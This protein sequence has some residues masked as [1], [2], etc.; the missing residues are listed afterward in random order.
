MRI[1]KS[2]RSKFIVLVV[3][4]CL[5]LSLT[6]SWFLTR[7]YGREMESIRQKQVDEIMKTV[8]DSINVY[9]KR[10]NLLFYVLQNNS[11][12]KKILRKEEYQNNQELFQD[13]ET[14]KEILKN[15]MIGEEYI[16]NI[17]LVSEK[18]FYFSGGGSEVES[19][20]NGLKQY[21]KACEDKEIGIIVEAEEDHYGYAKLKF[22]KKIQVT[23]QAPEFWCVM[24]VSCKALY[25]SYIGENTYKGTLIVYDPANKVINYKSNHKEIKMTDEELAEFFENFDKTSGNIQEINEQ[26][27][28]ISCHKSDI[29]DW[30]NYILIPYSDILGDGKVRNMITFCLA[31]F[32]VLAAFGITAR[33]SKYFLKNIKLLT[34][35]VENVTTE[36]L[37]I[38]C[39]IH[40]GDEVEQLYNSFVEMTKR[41]NEEM[42]ENKKSERE[43]IYLEQYALQ[44]QIKPHFLYNTLYTIKMLATMTGAEAIENITEALST[45]M[46]VNMSA[47]QFYTFTEAMD[48]LEKYICI[49]EYQYVG[50]I[51]FTYEIEKGLEQKY[52]LKM[53]LQPLVENSIK[54]GHIL[55]KENGKIEV[56]IFSEDAKI[57]AEVYDNGVGMDAAVRECIRR[58]E[59]KRIGLKNIA[60]R[61]QLYYGDSYGME[62]Q[63]VPGEYTRV[64]LTLP[65]EESEEKICLR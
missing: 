34:D 62:I 24:T 31:L 12:V 46:Q 15:A 38:D 64:I 36:H 35:S 16:R 41:L 19:S 52:I 2:L 49:R 25:K 10:M 22:I 56:R 57:K 1:R 11:S 54:H 47:E 17:A 61:I 51:N 23:E 50:E 29:V 7:M 28:F 48:Y 59:T 44:A 42:E 4:E 18:G 33:V 27:Y 63:S 53:L 39:S 65:M 60:R 6:S 14:M 3:M 13:M 55:E 45:I 5:I 43:K 20:R 32:L 8:N 40:S 37:A 26:E 21:Q 9:F 30:D 58:Q